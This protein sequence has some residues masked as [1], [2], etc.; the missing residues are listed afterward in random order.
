M[1][2]LWL[3]I[4]CFFTGYN[5]QIVKNSS[6]LAAKTVKKN[7][8]ALIIICLVWGFVGYSFTTRYLHGNL[9]TSLAV[10]L[11]M[12]IVVIQIE[13]QIILTIHRNTLAYVFRAFIGLVMAFIGSLILDQVIFKDDIEKSQLELVQQRVNSVLPLKTQE[14]K[15]QMAQIVESIEAKEAE[16]A[17]LLEELR[18]TPTIS[19]PT[20][21][22]RYEKD[23]SG[24]MALVGREVT[25]QA[26]PNPKAEL[27]PRIDE[28]LAQLRNNLNQKEE[29]LLNMR[30]SIE[31]DIASKTGFLDEL[32]TLFTIITSSWY[33]IIV[34]TLLFLFFMSLELFILVNKLSDKE[35][36]YDAVI[37]HQ[38]K[39]RNSALEKLTENN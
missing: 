25:Y 23:S 30:N 13:R 38:V 35:T 28:Q 15:A 14:L 24:R 33:S 26:V 32:K 20:S 3:K 10:A 37:K 7:M 34:W 16:R 5:Y 17:A 6:E 31:A 8:S 39:V 12:V 29:Y 11:V 21:I 36:D 19:T 9:L 2:N 1:N 18:R 22:G 4:S 27:I